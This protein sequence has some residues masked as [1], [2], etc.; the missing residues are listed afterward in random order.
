MIEVSNQE[1]K[2]EILIVTKVAYKIITYSHQIWIFK[3]EFSL[4]FSFFLI[5]DHFLKFILI[6]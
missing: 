4:D 5:V 2:L 3:N 6:N 1:V